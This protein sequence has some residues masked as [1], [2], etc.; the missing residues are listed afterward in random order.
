M[1]EIVTTAVCHGK[2]QIP[3]HAIQI[4]IPDDETEPHYV[5]ACPICLAPQHKAMTSQIA[6]MLVAVG[7]RV[8]R[9][10]DEVAE[11]YDERAFDRWLAGLR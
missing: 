6:A 4:L 8:V 10:A 3:E 7:C 11:T 2:V 1:T 5:F 9:V